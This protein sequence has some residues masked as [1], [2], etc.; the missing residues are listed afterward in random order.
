MTAIDNRSRTLGFIA[1]ATFLLIALL[2]PISAAAQSSAADALKQATAVAKQIEA[3]TGAASVAGKLPAGDPCTI[4]SP[5]DVK[6]VFPG[7]SSPERS[8]RLEQYG[9]TECQWKDA[10]G[11]AVLV[12]QQSIAAASGTARSEA[13]GM[14][15]GFVD[16]MNRKA[17]DSIRIEKFSAIGA[18]NAAFVEAADPARGIL[19]G[20]AFMALVNGG[21][22]VTILSRDLASQDRAAGLKAL[23]RLGAVAV[24]R[25]E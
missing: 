3:K 18:D 20:G 22:L 6:A 15:E 5:A 19:S 9:T 24:K 12:V 10:K 4:V 11:Q 1:P 23:A 2:Q 17:L 25:V 16:P 13:L 21:Q 7:V 14:A 8:R